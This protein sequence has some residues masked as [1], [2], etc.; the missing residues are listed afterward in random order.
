M[1]F[2]GRAEFEVCET[3]RHFVTN[4]SICLYADEWVIWIINL[5]GT[6]GELILLSQ[7]WDRSFFSSWE[8][9]AL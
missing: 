4:G 5:G 1:G 2:R 7:F 3:E 6:A 9:I 8:I